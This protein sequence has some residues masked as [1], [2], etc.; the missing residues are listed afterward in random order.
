MRKNP[1]PNQ[2]EM[3][4]FMGKSLHSCSK[5]WG[6]GKWTQ[7]NFICLPCSSLVSFLASSSKLPRPLCA[8]TSTSR[9][10]EAEPEK[11]FLLAGPKWEA[12]LGWLKEVLGCFTWKRDLS[13]S[14]VLPENQ[15]VIANVPWE[16]RQPRRP[17]MSWKGSAEGTLPSCLLLSLSKHPGWIWKGALVPKQS[18]P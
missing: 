15:G 3:C 11:R 17:G 6:R 16:Q 12:R 2:A 1:L 14:A 5:E 4:F 18:F 13:S 9:P 7:R 10:S 8:D